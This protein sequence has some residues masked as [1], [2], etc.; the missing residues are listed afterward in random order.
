MFTAGGGRTEKDDPDDPPEVILGAF[1][2]FGY[3][4]REK[5]GN[6]KLH[7]NEIR[8]MLKLCNVKEERIPDNAIDVLTEGLNKLIGNAANNIL[9]ANLEL[10]EGSRLDHRNNVIRSL[11]DLQI[12]DYLCLNEDRHPGNLM[13]QVN[14]EGIITG[15]QGIDNDSSFGR[16]RCGQVENSAL[17]VISKT[18]ADKVKKL[19][20][21]MLRFAL[22]GRGLSDEEVTAAVDRLSDLKKLIRNK[23]VRTVRDDKFNELSND[24][25]FPTD[26]D[27]FISDLNIGET[28]MVY[29]EA[30]NTMNEKVTT[31]LQKKTGERGLDERGR[32]RGKNDYEKKRPCEKGRK[33]GGAGTEKPS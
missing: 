8:Q 29:D 19:S 2:A 13:Y 28:L 25:M 15:I 22:R 30:F 4:V 7:G 23:T 14:Q 31:Y 1:L 17:K 20:P 5:K 10:P 12:I 33:T 32:I 11:A 18:M 6:R 26:K 24:Q 21:E 9:T 3:S 27:R 16:R